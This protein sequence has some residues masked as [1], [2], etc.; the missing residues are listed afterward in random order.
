[1]EF[2][3]SSG[4]PLI[5]IN[6]IEAIS[7]ENHK[8]TKKKKKQKKRVNKSKKMKKHKKVSF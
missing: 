2:F 5:K 1:M 3:K 7:Q 6:D 8:T 4:Q